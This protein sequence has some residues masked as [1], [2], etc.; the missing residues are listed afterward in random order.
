[1]GR[2]NPYHLIIE[3]V[4]FGSVLKLADLYL[5]IVFLCTFREGPSEVG[6]PLLSPA[7]LTPLFIPLQP[8][9]LHPRWLRIGESRRSLSFHDL[10]MFQHTDLPFG[11]S[12]SY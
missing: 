4:F 1:M 8:P 11:A 3:F 10:V 7:H 2:R 12:S 6:L 9:K 5:G